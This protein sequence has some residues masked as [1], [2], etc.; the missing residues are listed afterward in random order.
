[1]GLLFVLNL[2]LLAS[3][4]KFNRLPPPPLCLTLADCMNYVWVQP[5]FPALGPADTCSPFT[6]FQTHIQASLPKLVQIINSQKSSNTA[7]NASQPH[8][9]VYPTQGGCPVLSPPEQGGVDAH[10]EIN[11]EAF[12]KETTSS[13]TPKGSE[14]AGV[15]KATSRTLCEPQH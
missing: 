7:G 4:H 8:P 3:P 13:P 14:G 9:Q 5:S 11:R 10:T 12:A 15:V 2:A 6:I 1:M